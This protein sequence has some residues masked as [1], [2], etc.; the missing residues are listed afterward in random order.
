[1]AQGRGIRSDWVTL[2]SA[3]NVAKAIESYGVVRGIAGHLDDIE[4]ILLTLAERAG[5]NKH[6]PTW[7]APA[8][9]FDEIDAIRLLVD[10]HRYQL[11]NVS[12]GE[13]HKACTL[14]V[15]RVRSGGGEVVSA[16]GG[17]A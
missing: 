4:A 1:M 6:P 17:K 3:T 8:L 2:C 7:R 5:E 12:H 9:R 10:L 15:A 13:Y 16:K 14:A 11:Q